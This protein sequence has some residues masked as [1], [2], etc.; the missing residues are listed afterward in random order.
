V[1]AENRGVVDPIAPRLMAV[2][3]EHACV[4]FAVLLLLLC[5]LLLTFVTSVCGC[6]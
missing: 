4:L 6:T 2:D 3:A 1:W 5:S